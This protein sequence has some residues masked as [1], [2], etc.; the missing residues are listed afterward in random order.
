MKVNLSKK[1]KENILWILDMFIDTHNESGLYKK[2]IK[3][4][5]KL[6]NQLRN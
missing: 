3:V 5:Q 6:I 1:D 4:A 2:E